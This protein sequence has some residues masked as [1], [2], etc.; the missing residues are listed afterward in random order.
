MLAKYPELT[1]FD[2]VNYL[3]SSLKS[4]EAAEFVV[5]EVRTT[6]IHPCLR[7]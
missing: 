6:T 2:R 3:H 7:N 5:D 4:K 1:E